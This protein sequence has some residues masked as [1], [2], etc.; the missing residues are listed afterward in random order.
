LSHNLKNEDNDNI[1]NN[2]D[3]KIDTERIASVII[4]RYYKIKT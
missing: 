2:N 1:E 4:I 3:E